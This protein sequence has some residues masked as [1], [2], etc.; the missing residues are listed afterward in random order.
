MTRGLVGYVAFA[1]ACSWNSGNIGPAT[2]EIG[3]G[4]DVS[5]AAVGLLGGTAF[6][7]GLVAAKLGAARLTER[8]GPEA[9][10]RLTVLAALVGNVVIALSP[11][12]AGVA[13]G[14]VLAGVG[15]GLALV[16]G[17]VFARAA[18]GDRYVGGFGA[19]VTAGVAAAIGIGSVMRT[20]GVDWRLD[21]ALAAAIAGVALLLLPDAPDKRIPS[22]SVLALARRWGR[23]AR[24]WRL[25][26]LF[27]TALGLPYVLG[28]WLVPFLDGVTGLSIGVAGVLG[29]TM[30]A[31]NAFFRPEGA[32]LEADPA[33]L[34]LLGGV[35]PLIGAAGLVLVALADGLAL[36][37]AGVALAAIGFG[38]PYAT[39]YAEA[40]RLF[41]DARIA[42]VG[43]FSVGGN[44]LPLAATPLV[45][46]AIAGGNGREAMFAL[47]AV[48]VLAG[49]ANLRPVAP[50]EPGE[51]G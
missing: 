16:L 18:G 47:A 36:A 11:W 2:G 37:A 34:P 6:F 24:A 40:V 45:G 29:A 8:T 7:A 30:F 19:A 27:T 14:R 23:S 51:A 9:A 15:L 3:A 12:F 44:I 46:A 49:L 28:V 25:E 31:L 38:L 35:A 33:R 39:M 17:P 42:A 48:A 32:R 21:F 4:L 41:P 10:L 1:A 50:P 43:L 22:G 26:L 13:L 5:L 20:A